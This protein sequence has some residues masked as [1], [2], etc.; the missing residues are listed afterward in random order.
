VI[1]HRTL[2]HTEAAARVVGFKGPLLADGK[3][4]IGSRCAMWVPELVP[5]SEAGGRPRRGGWHMPRKGAG[6]DGWAAAAEQDR[7]VGRGWCADN[8]RRE[9]WGD[10]A[11]KEPT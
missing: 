1:C 7:L 10:P 8:L 6:R 5:L 3:T 11:A 9:P 2:G 4:C